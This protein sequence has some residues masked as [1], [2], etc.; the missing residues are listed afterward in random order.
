MVPTPFV[1]LYNKAYDEVKD[2]K[3]KIRHQMKRLANRVHRYFRLMEKEKKIRQEIYQVYTRCLRL[4]H[5][6]S[7]FSVSNIYHEKLSF[8]SSEKRPF[9]LLNLREQNRQ[10]KLGG[11]T[12][13]TPTFCRY[14]SKYVKYVIRGK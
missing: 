4:I 5:I 2:H 13:Y 14:L 12:P 8:F 9:G 1:P 11:S 10:T 7:I 6:T 3:R